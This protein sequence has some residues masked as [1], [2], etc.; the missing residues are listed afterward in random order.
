MSN[1]ANYYDSNVYNY[2]AWRLPCGI[3]ERTNKV[4][5]T[6]YSGPSITWTTASSSTGSGTTVKMPTFDGSTETTA[7]INGVKVEG[8]A[9]NV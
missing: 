2:C 7:T 6:G 3:C 5:P 1:T 8:R 9:C 4:C